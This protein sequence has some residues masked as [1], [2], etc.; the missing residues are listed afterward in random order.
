MFIDIAHA[1]QTMMNSAIFPC[2][3]TDTSGLFR[4]LDTYREKKIW[5]FKILMCNTFSVIFYPAIFSEDFLFF[6]S[7]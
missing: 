7:L 2:Y 4:S 1:F 3:N 5:E 6:Q